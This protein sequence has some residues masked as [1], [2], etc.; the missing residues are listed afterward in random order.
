MRGLPCRSS[1]PAHHQTWA[2]T[3]IT[4]TSSTFCSRRGSQT[5]IACRNFS[6]AFSTALQS[7]TTRTA[8]VLPVSAA[9]L[10]E[11]FQ[12]VDIDAVLDKDSAGRVLRW[13]DCTYGCRNRCRYHRRPAALWPNVPSCHPQHAPS[14]AILLALQ[15]GVWHGEMAGGPGAGSEGPGGDVLAAVQV[16]AARSRRVQLPSACA[17]LTCLAACCS[18]LW[19]LSGD[20]RWHH[21]TTQNPTALPAGSRCR[22]ARA[23]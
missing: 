22:S 20:P 4:R 1:Q 16:M 7:G 21:A 11:T 18:L 17:E 8:T 9:Q 12:A 19:T 14:C 3:L 13:G 10:A 2:S 15:G 6:S 23:P 5:V